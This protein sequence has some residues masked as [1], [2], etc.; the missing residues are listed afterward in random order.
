MDEGGEEEG[1]EQNE[2]KKKRLRM[3]GKEDKKYLKVE[4]LPQM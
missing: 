3:R 2:R 1:E 4:P